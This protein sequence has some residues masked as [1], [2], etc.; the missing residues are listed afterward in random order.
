MSEIAIYEVAELQQF[1][2]SNST[3]V[4]MAPLDLKSDY[5]MLDGGRSSQNW[6]KWICLH[7]WLSLESD[8]KRSKGKW[9][10]LKE[11]FSISD[12][13]TSFEHSDIA[14]ECI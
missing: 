9:E 8:N 4:A 14:H 1:E 5:A 3:A 12:L 7:L 2:R 10:D 13:Y 11:S 6:S